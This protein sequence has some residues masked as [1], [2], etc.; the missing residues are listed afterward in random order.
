[1]VYTDYENS[2]FISIFENYSKFSIFFSFRNISGV[3]VKSIKYTSMRYIR[4]RKHM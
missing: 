2:A 4:T 3:D 1:M